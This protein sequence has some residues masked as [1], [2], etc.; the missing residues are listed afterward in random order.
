MLLEAARRAGVQRFI[1]SAFGFDAD[2]LPYVF[3]P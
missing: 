2:K 3:H 1:P